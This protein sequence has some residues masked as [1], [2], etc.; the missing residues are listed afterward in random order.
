MASIVIAEK[1]SQAKL[2]RAAVGARYG[3]IL[4]ALGH[5]FEL[6]EPED[7]NP[8]WK[9]WSVGI[10]RPE[11][12]FYPNRLRKDGGARKNY[13][14]IKDAAKSADTIYVATDPDREGEGIGTNIVNALR[15]DIGWS[16]RVL[17]VIQNA[18]D[19]KTLVD[20]FANARPA[21]AYKALYQ[22][23]VARQQADQIF[24][25]SLTRT[26]SVLF[27]PPG[28]KGALSVGRVLTPTLG[29]VCR[30]EREIATF[31][32]VDYFHPWVEVEGTAG[33][34]KLT[35]AP[36][37]SDRIFDRA[38]ARRLSEA[39]SSYA[40]PIRV[41]QQRKAQPPPPLFS[42]AKLQVEAARRFKWP[43]AKTTE[44]LQSIYEANAVTYPRSSETSL[45]EAE[46]ANA[47]A[48]L[49]GLLRVP[50]IGPVTWASNGP[51]IRVKA[52]AF[53]DKDLAG[54][55][56]FAIVPNVNTADQWPRLCERMTVDERRLFDLIAR[57][58]L[59]AIGPDRIY[60]STRLWVEIEQREFAA[61]GT[62]ELEAGWRE[63]LGSHDPPSDPD[64]SD[65]AGA[66]PPFRDGEHVE[67]RA[68]G[69]LDKQTSPPPR[70]TD[71]TLIVA[72][73]EAWRH[74]EDA[75][76]R[77]ILKET[78]GIGTEATRKDI[79]VNLMGRGLV[80]PAEKKGGALKASPA[81]MQF[82][83]ILE[84]AAPHL[85]DVGLTGRMELMLERIKSGTEKATAVVHEIV[86]VA[87]NAVTSM[88]AAKDGGAG[89][90]ATQKRPP[91]EGM[92]KAARAKAA[93]E[94][95]R[96]PPGVLSD[97]EACRAFLG[98]LPERSAGPRPPSEKA[99]ALA[100]KI[101]TE[102]GLDLPSELEA[103]AKRL[104]D[105]ID[106]QT[107]GSTAKGAARGGGQPQSGSLDPRPT[108]KQV[109]FAEKIA[110]RKRIEIP[111]ECYR[112]RSPMSKWID[113]QGGG[114]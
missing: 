113:A 114:R 69:V 99:L 107:R 109:G 93:R 77:A 48:M 21:D 20:A 106:G 13:A 18:Q 73:I 14:A 81:G 22:S 64:D 53:S 44:V 105:W 29:L 30:R 57:R 51:V 3:P 55:A 7:V 52:G 12:G 31:E 9:T 92:K 80:E 38:V 11:G 43:V 5:L 24:N 59:A 1:P 95:I 72:M 62:V 82:F 89:I 2:Y 50:G 66:L 8:E 42:L 112:D 103:D 47:P 75:E 41:R 37:E 110:S 108:S 71:A 90:T 85:L 84:R 101:A 88:V 36:P 79:V 83:G 65:D 61:T 17:R 39:A 34:V 35:H 98:P 32:P 68:S 10:L 76:L 54:A 25:L 26:A 33:R 78:E 16:G 58:Y 6:A 104:S 15:R 46:I 74:V 91:S 45:P 94:G 96:L 40:G 49:A 102:R 70:Y 67:A 97:A 4:P 27:K 60:D 100:R 28:W 56:H 87:E 23:F 86:G 63:A 19:E 111:D